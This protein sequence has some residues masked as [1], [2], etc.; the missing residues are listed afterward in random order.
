MTYN[1]AFAH[2]PSLDLEIDDVVQQIRIK[3]WQ[4][5]QKQVLRSPRAYIARMISTTL[6]D[7]LRSR[8]PTFRLFLDDEGEPYASYPFIEPG[9]GMGDPEHEISQ[10]AELRALLVEV[11]LP[12]QT[13]PL[14]QQ[15]ALLSALWDRI[16]DLELLRSVLQRM[17]FDQIELE[18]FIPR[19]QLTA[20]RRR[21]AQELHS[22]SFQAHFFS[23]NEP[24][25]GTTDKLAPPEN[26]RRPRDRVHMKKDHAYPM[27]QQ[28]QRMVSFLNEGVTSKP[29]LDIT[30]FET[31]PEP[32][33]TAIRLC[34]IEHLPYDQ[35]ACIFPKERSVR[36]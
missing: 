9:E 24:S 33:R 36:R 3:L 31:L 2:S 28:P 4:T 8:E 14:R 20:A 26:L 10:E 18:A 34:Y 1:P 16:D 13:F 19:H 35:I 7:L 21:L 27:D 15:V 12:L 11:L 30:Q 32:S 17:G 25:S 6:V 23:S 29:P 5:V 22:S